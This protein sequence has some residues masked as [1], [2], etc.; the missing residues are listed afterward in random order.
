MSRHK[1]IAR[2]ARRRRHARGGGQRGPR[3]LITYETYTPESVEQGD[4]AE[5]G[6]VDED[7]VSCKP[8]SYDRK[9][10]LTAVDLAVKMMQHEG[11]CE[12]SSS[13][14]HRGVWYTNPNASENYQTGETE[15][16]SYHLKGFTSSQE[17]EIFRR[18]TR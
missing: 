3:I 8:D 18:M 13:H 7:G 10:G 14:F 9:A 15:S 5:R 11:A 16:R 1:K 2:K 6:W 4:A 17:R 12:P